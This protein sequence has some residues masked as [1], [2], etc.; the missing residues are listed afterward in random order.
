LPII[1]P[2]FLQV[3]KQEL[4]LLAN[5]L[6]PSKA[7]G[8]A[9]LGKGLKDE[10]KRQEAQGGA[11]EMDYGWGGGRFGKRG[12]GDMLDYGWGGGRFGKRNGELMDYG[13]G[14]GRFGKRSEG[15]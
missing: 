14:G 15:G 1:V 13:W 2:T 3:R 7:R 5:L 9:E 4:Y 12:G 8:R 6:H 11:W 10:K